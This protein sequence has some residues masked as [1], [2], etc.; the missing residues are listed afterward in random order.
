KRAAFVELLSAIDGCQHACLRLAWALTAG[1][2]EEILRQMERSLNALNR[3]DTAVSVT[4]LTV[5]PEHMQ[6]LR[7]GMVAC[8]QELDNARKG[9]PYTTATAGAWNPILELA[10]KE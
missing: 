10:R 6:T 4:A 8:I 2:Q 3:V 1:D 5:G 9:S 7:N